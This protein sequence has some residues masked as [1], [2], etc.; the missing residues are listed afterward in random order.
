MKKL[1]TFSLF[2]LSLTV[3][4]S[5]TV[6]LDSSGFSYKIGYYQTTSTNQDCYLKKTSPA[7]ESIWE[8]LYDSSPVDCKGLAVSFDNYNNKIWAAFSVDGGSYDSG[9]ITKKEIAASALE[10]V[11]FSS[12]GRGGGPKVSFISRINPLTG[13]IEKATFLLART[14]QGNINAVSK[15]NTLVVKDINAR[16]DGVF[17]AVDS[18]YMPPSEE[19]ARNNF[20]FLANATAEN[21]FG[22]GSWRVLYLL[23]FELDKIIKARVANPQNNEPVDGIPF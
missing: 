10:N 8:K 3:V 17:V 13:V 21:K 19:S 5:G 6:T 12:Y 4:F 20:L 14:S 7:N 18:Y 15:T 11:I 22:K 9:Y 2:L 16:N 1:S 23:S